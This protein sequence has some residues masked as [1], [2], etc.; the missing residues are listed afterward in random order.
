[1]AKGCAEYTRKQLDEL[2]DYEKRPQVGAIGL[3]YVQCQAD[4]TFK[5]YAD[6]SYSDD[7]LKAWANKF[8]AQ[9]GDFLLFLSGETNSVRKK[10]NELRLLMGEKLGLRDKN[11]FAALW[12][13][14]FPLLEWNEESQR[15]HAMHHPF[16]SPKPDDIKLLDTNPG[17]VRANAY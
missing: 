9:P 14:D 7:V 12:V 10:L 6:K 3:L 8:I 1:C 17:A 15:Y 2:T 11:K 5:S 16:T 4:G 13:I